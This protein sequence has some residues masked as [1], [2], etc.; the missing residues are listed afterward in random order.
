MH[1]FTIRIAAKK[2]MAAASKFATPVVKELGFYNKEQMARNIYEMSAK[3]LKANL[4][5]YRDSVIIAITKEGKIVG[6]LTH[7]VGLNHVD[8]LDWILVDQRFRKKG[9][10][11][12]MLNY[13]IQ[14]AK[15]NGCHKIWCDT[16]P[17]NK[18]AIK[19]FKRM[20][21]RKIGIARKHSFGQDVIFWE[22]LF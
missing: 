19:F 3:E 13:A 9:L 4:K 16:D 15:R 21:F 6:L 20:G 17:N 22:R 7:F 12:A 2:D 11:K 1:D 8:W 18:Q 10:G 5:I 14:N